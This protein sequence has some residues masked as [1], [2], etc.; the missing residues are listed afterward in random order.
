MHGGEKVQQ[1][2]PDKNKQKTK[3]ERGI[4]CITGFLL[5]SSRIG[6]PLDTLNHLSDKYLEIHGYWFLLVL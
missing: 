5:N 3:K 4:E 1:K 6:I 2:S